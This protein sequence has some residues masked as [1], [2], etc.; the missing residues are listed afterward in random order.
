MKK[1]Y[2]SL[3]LVSVLVLILSV[4]VYASDGKYGGTLIVGR[5]SDSVGLDAANVT[6]GESQKVMRQIY[7]TL[8]RYK[9]GTTEV[10]PSIAKSWEVSNN[11]K[12]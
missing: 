5:G 1:K 8:T 2:Y 3:L 11:A 7:D 6:D 9:P 10:I 12:T 4:S